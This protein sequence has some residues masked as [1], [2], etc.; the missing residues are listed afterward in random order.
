M[1][2]AELIH[3]LAVAF[4]SG[5]FDLDKDGQANQNDFSTTFELMMSQECNIYGDFAVE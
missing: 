5:S 1:M 2:P 4:L 3:D